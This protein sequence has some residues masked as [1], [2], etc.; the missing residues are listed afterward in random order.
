MKAGDSNG[1]STYSILL[2]GLIDFMGNIQVFFMICEDMW[3]SLGCFALDIRLFMSVP[4]ME[5]WAILSMFWVHY[6]RSGRIFALT[7]EALIPGM[8]RV[9][10]LGIVGLQNSCVLSSRCGPRW[11]R[12]CA[13]H[14]VES[15]HV[16]PE[17]F[18]TAVQLL[19]DLLFITLMRKYFLGAW[20]VEKLNWAKGRGIT[21]LF[22]KNSSFFLH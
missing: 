18:L 1:L 12:P 14:Y 8:T 2:P 7:L 11:A 9:G 13:L 10:S 15:I 21:G 19:W 17:K 5:W 20:I 4:W 16:C 3:F 6:M 22:A